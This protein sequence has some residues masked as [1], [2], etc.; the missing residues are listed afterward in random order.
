M[1]TS[2]TKFSQGNGRQGETK[3]V[4]EVSNDIN[5]IEF[6]FDE[7]PQKGPDFDLSSSNKIEPT[8]IQAQ[9]RITSDIIAQIQA[10]DNKDALTGFTQGAATKSGKRQCYIGEFGINLHV[11][12]MSDLVDEK[13]RFVYRTVDITRLS[14]SPLGFFIRQ[15]DGLFKK[16]G[17]FVSRVSEGSVVDANGLLE[18]G[19]EIVQ[20]NGVDVAGFSLDD[21]VQMIKIPKRLVLTVKTNSYLYKRNLSVGDEFA[22]IATSDKKVEKRS[23]NTAKIRGKTRA[24]SYNDPGNQSKQTSQ[25][26]TQ[27]FDVGSN[28]NE[29]INST[30]PTS[31]STNSSTIEDLIEAI[32]TQN[33]RSRRGHH[34]HEE[35]F[36]P[37]CTQNSSSNASDNLKLSDKTS[38][39]VTR[40]ALNDISPRKPPLI[41]NRKSSTLT[42]ATTVNLV[43]DDS[44]ELTL[45]APAPGIY[46]EWERKTKDDDTLK[47]HTIT[48]GLRT[49]PESPGQSPKARRKLPSVPTENSR[50]T[51][52]SAENIAGTPSAKPLL[53]LPGEPRSRRM[54]PTPPPSPVSQHK[55]STTVPS[56]SDKEDQ[57]ANRNSWSGPLERER[58]EER[59]AGVSPTR[60][61]AGLSISHLL[62]AFA[63]R[64]HQE[65]NG[66]YDKGKNTHE[67]SVNVNNS[68][69][70]AH[71]PFRKDRHDSD[72]LEQQRHSMLL[73]SYAFGS[74]HPPGGIRKLVSRSSQP[75][76][77]VKEDPVKPKHSTLSFPDDTENPKHPLRLNRRRASLASVTDKS[78]ANHLASH[79]LADSDRIRSEAEADFL[80]FPDDYGDTNLRS[81]HAVS[82]MVSLHLIKATNLQ[83]ADRKLLEKKKK[84]HCAVEMDFERKAFTSSKRASKT[85]TWDEMFDVEVQHGREICLS[86]FTSSHEF[87]KPVAK[88]SF[89]L[90]PFVR[91]GQRH[92]V[93][94]RM[95]PQGA[96]HVEMEFIEMKTLLQ[97]APSQ[98]ESGVFGFQLNVT[99]RIENSSV[100]LI[101]RKCVEEIDKRG[102]STQGLYRISGN[103]RRK[104]L[105]HAQFD[106]D[107]SAVDLSEENYPDINVIAGILKDYLRELPEPLITP[108]MSKMLV[109][110]AQD[111][112]QDKDLLSQK[113][114]LSKLLVQLPEINRETLVYLLNHFAR[115]TAQ[116]DNNKMDAH[117]LSVCFG[118]LL[119]CPPANLT[120]SKDLLNLKLHNKVVEFLFFLWTNAGLQIS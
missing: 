103:A 76:L 114:L 21:V 77:I 2:T 82:G 7:Q 28:T 65:G 62:N 3:N 45:T 38:D 105:L 118:P 70:E 6:I 74:S 18:V 88:V 19:D 117:N 32:R 27:N 78:L 87:N 67:S 36:Q 72:I 85:L 17:I 110:A 92:K 9:N 13:E 71:W 73:H 80:I 61:E 40:K 84:V 83:F 111:H 53:N 55:A 59:S 108:S 5:E 94:F 97:R 54:L 100:P 33:S 49:P 58:G 112:V 89:N 64:S 43:F 63:F 106:E 31:P 22:F 115:V 86:C 8:H 29:T 37:G 93:V 23:P 66:D 48:S 15:G 81:S 30:R 101:V 69:A 79:Y 41:A 14:S 113:R 50:L 24:D 20:V 34:E 109:K 120:E 90:A 42:P 107:S 104:R 12:E 95:H 91:C 96:L 39:S 57:K 98:R 11:P 56:S 25:T 46:G 44:E 68:S 52:P 116:K 1:W 35:L 4:G 10:L 51:R 75:N 47:V 119:L 99:S 102:L 16:C 26:E 60:K